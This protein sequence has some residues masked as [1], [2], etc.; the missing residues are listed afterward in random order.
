MAEPLNNGETHG[1]AWPDGTIRTA[2]YEPGVRAIVKNDNDGVALANK[3]YEPLR[4]A[5]HVT[6][7]TLD[8]AYAD[9]LKEYTAW[10]KRY[11]EW[12]AKYGNKV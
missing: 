3:P 6:Q 10:K 4:N 9:W 7:A 8:K 1:Y 5:P 11:A 12:E 2:P